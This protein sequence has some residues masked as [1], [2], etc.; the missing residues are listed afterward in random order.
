[1]I[2]LKDGLGKRVAVY[3]TT[4]KALRGAADLLEAAELRE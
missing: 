1:V 4:A 2:S 3:E